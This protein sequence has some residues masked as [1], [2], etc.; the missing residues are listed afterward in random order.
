MY[1]KDWQRYAKSGG[2]RDDIMGW[3]CLFVSASCQYR[4]AEGLCFRSCKV[5]NPPMAPAEK[6]FAL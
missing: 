2:H 3:Q 4:D 5:Q 1:C 6:C